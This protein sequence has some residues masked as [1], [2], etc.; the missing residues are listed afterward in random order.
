MFMVPGVF[1]GFYK[2]DATVAGYGRN[3]G[4]LFSCGSLGPATSTFENQHT[5]MQYRNKSL[6]TTTV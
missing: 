6:D 4:P 2:P 5:T 3:T 1:E